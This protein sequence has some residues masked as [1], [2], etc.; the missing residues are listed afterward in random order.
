MVTSGLLKNQES[1]KF[2]PQCVICAETSV[3]ILRLGSNF[4]VVCK[5][6]SVK[7]SKRELE[8]MHN[9]FLAYGGH[10]GKLNSSKEEAY[11]ELEKIAKEY[12]KSGKDVA[13]IESDVKNLIRAFLHGITPIQLVKGLQVLS[14]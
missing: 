2:V 8:L 5:E 13:R 14:D 6:C 12:S 9:M 10:F 7:F 11:Q 4:S 3:R 1:K